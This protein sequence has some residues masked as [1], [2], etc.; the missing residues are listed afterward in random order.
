MKEE[1]KISRKQIKKLKNDLIP[2]AIEEKGSLKLQYPMV[3]LMHS[4]DKASNIATILTI[5]VIVLTSILI[6]IGILSF[7]RGIK[8]NPMADIEVGRYEIFKGPYRVENLK[9]SRIYEHDELFKLDTKTGEVYRYYVCL[10]PGDKHKEGWIST[11]FIQ[12]IPHE[13]KD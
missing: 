6:G 2:Q 12:D 11:E 9:G 3:L 4:V 10:T 1:K 5:V 8:I 13:R 7:T